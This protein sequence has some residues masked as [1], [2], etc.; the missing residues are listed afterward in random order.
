ML[1]A[2]SALLMVLIIEV[3]ALAQATMALLERFELLALV[4]TVVVDMSVAKPLLVEMMLT[5]QSPLGLRCS[6]VAAIRSSSI[7]ILWSLSNTDLEILSE[8]DCSTGFENS[9]LLDCLEMLDCSKSG[10]SLVIVLQ[11]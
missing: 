1:S 11:G 6:L 7:D 2:L 8:R 9:L 3:A 10:M 5:L 4:V